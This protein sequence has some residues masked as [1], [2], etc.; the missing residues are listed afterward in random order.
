MLFTWLSLVMSMMVS[1][2][3]VLFPTRC[4]G[5]DLGL[6]WVSFWGFS[7]LL[8]LNL[9]YLSVSNPVF[10]T[11]HIETNPLLYVA[12]SSRCFAET[13]FNAGDKI[14]ILQNRRRNG[15]NNCTKCPYFASN[16]SSWISGRDGRRKD[17]I[18][19]F[20][21]SMCRTGY[22]TRYVSLWFTEITNSIYPWRISRA[23]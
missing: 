9:H 8:L 18:I 1:F 11:L 12:P 23:A 21:E 14:E 2:C 7:F 15:S 13:L 20:H 10:T 6:N 3:A 4:L 19:N 17:F 22:R 16:C 5:W